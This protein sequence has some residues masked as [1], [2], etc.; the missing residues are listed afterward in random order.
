MN[1][2]KMDELLR[3]MR[4]VVPDTSDMSDA[5]RIGFVTRGEY[6][7]FESYEKLDVVLYGGSLWTPLKDTTGNPPPD[8]QRNEDGTPAENEFWSL[9]LPGALGDDYVKKTDI[10]VAPT[11]TE[12]G[13]AGVNFPDGKTIQIDENGM[14]TGTPLDFTGTWKELQAGIESGEI[15][16]GMVGYIKGAKGETDGTEDPD[17]PNN[18]LFDFDDFLSLYSRNAPQNRV[19]TAML[20]QIKELA[21]Q[22]SQLIED[23]KELRART[24]AFGLAKICPADV[25]DVTEDNGLVLG[26]VEKNPSAPG[27]LAESIGKLNRSG[28][29]NLTPNTNLVGNAPGNF[30]GMVFRI[31]SFVIVYAKFSIAYFVSGEV[32]FSIPNGYRP[33]EDGTGII[34]ARRSASKGLYF[35]AECN[36]HVNGNIVQTFN[37]DG[38]GAEWEGS[39]F[40]CYQS[41]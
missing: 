38:M 1:E 34:S 14:M 33:M 22:N 32:M 21:E 16:D 36:V 20:N 23:V 12:P 9:F 40:S 35:N 7:D 37:N 19:V 27:S 30:C 3:L 10:A 6:S 2:E 15:T 31:G 4:S 5:G 28:R 25:T 24:D 39:I 11:E 29:A 17:H 18:M 8:N 41:E 26:A 13:K